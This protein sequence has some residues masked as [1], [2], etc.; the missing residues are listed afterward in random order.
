MDCEKL[1][2]LLEIWERC[3]NIQPSDNRGKSLLTLITNHII[4]NV[5]FLIEEAIQ[6]EEDNK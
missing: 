6:K 3:S 5:E 2:T 1:N 4:E